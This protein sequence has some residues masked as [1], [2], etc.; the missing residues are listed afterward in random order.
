MTMVRQYPPQPQPQPQLFALSPSLGPYSSL[1]A[2]PRAPRRNVLGYDL[3]SLGQQQLPQQYAHPLQRTNSYPQ[4][5]SLKEQG[6]ERVRQSEHM[7]RRKTP[8]GILAAAYDGTSVEQTEKPHATK[9]ILLPVTAAESGLAN[10]GIFPYTLKQ[11]LPLRSSGMAP[12]TGYNALKQELP[13]GN[14]DPDMHFGFDPPKDNWKR[15]QHNLPQID[16]MLNQMP[17]QQQVLQYHHYGQQFCGAMEP[18]LQSPLGPTVSNDQGPYGP[19]WHDGTFIPYRPAAL[20]DPRYYHHPASN[21]SAPQPHGYLG[22]GMGDWQSFNNTVPNINAI[23]HGHHF[24][25]STPSPATNSYNVDTSPEHHFP[26]GFRTSEPTP[27]INHHRRNLG[28]DYQGQNLNTQFG[29]RTPHTPQDPHQP[30]S[31]SGQS[32]PVP[33]FTPVSTPLSEFG[34]QSS[35]AQ[36]RERVFTWAHTVYIDLLKYLQQTRRSSA[37]SRH[38]SGHHPPRPSIY[39]KPPRQPGATFSSSSSINSRSH[40]KGVSTPVGQPIQ[41]ESSDL[42]LQNRELIHK[43]HASHHRSSSLWLPTAVDQRDPDAQR[44]GSWQQQYANPGPGP[45]QLQGQGLETVRTLRR[46]SGTSVSGIHP[47]VRHDVSPTA[48]AASALEA[49]TKH[50][51][52]SSWQWIDGML[53]GGCLAYA[54]GDYQ[55]A[56]GWYSRILDLDSE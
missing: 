24:P 37:H 45:I 1:P 11:E 47:A 2:S 13:T 56:L 32:T 10:V 22:K 35:N 21:W 27:Q 34:P 8:N 30:L 41:S 23:Q 9:H 43:T 48:N 26:Y 29:H 5:G 19:Y 6:H 52:D 42:N 39:P 4:H 50:C 46:T 38:S 31:S 51:G 54:L 7:L 53:L 44:R 49:I 25:G 3:Q 33:E 28:L 17:L 14:W 15:A 16:S 18:S 40:E 12:N 36:L 55:K 20:R